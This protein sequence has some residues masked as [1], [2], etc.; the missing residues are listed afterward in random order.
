MRVTSLAYPEVVGLHVARGRKCRVL[1]QWV[2]V[3]RALVYAPPTSV[4][5]TRPVRERPV[6]RTSGFKPNAD[7]RKHLD[8][9]STSMLVC[10]RGKPSTLISSEGACRRRYLVCLR[11]CRRNRQL[12]PART[13]VPHGPHHAARRRLHRRYCSQCHALIAPQP[14]QRDP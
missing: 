6:R 11:R 10:P 7:E 12:D 2:I 5:A 3:R 13:V 8:A 1:R 4:K 9:H 14:T